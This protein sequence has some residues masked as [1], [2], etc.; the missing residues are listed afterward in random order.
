MKNLD[1]Q[2]KSST[3]YYLITSDSKSKYKFCYN[4]VS[5]RFEIMNA[6]FLCFIAIWNWSQKRV[7][8]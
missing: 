2:D 8:I 7:F 1:F 6:L 5:F 3:N 4:M